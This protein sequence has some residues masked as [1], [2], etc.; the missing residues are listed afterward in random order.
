MAFEWI[1]FGIAFATAT[2]TPII[3]ID[4]IGLVLSIISMIL[5]LLAINRDYIFR[6]KETAES[7][8]KEVAI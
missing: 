8:K 5:V 2:P 6:E 4:S 1:L 3:T 7:V